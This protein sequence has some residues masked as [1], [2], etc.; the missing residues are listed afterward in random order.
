MPLINQT[1]QA[2]QLVAAAEPLQRAQPDLVPGGSQGGV[3]GQLSLP[4]RPPRRVI[5]RVRDAAPRRIRRQ[6]SQNLDDMTLPPL[7]AGAD[8]PWQMLQTAPRRQHPAVRGDQLKARVGEQ[9]PDQHHRDRTAN[10][11]QPY[12]HP[13]QG[14]HLVGLA[15]EADLVTRSQHRQAAAG[16]PAD[17]T[18]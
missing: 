6:P 18:T 2:L 7:C 5:V 13:V 8:L 14:H 15:A 1:G 9:M 16:H 4:Q 10:T 11:G 3:L 12:R 17:L